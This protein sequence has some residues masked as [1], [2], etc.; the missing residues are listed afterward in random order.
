MDAGLRM[1]GLLALGLWDVVIEVLRSPNNTQTPIK[2]V[3][4][5]RYQTEE[6]SR[7]PSKV[8]LKGHR[9]VQ[10]FS[11]LNHVIANAHSQ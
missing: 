8:K 11:Q 1:D 7:S 6:C 2:S 9:G 3:S 4:G 5:H 10:Q